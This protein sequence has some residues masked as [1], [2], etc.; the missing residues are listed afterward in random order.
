MVDLWTIERLYWQFSPP[1]RD[2]FASDPIIERLKANAAQGRVLVLAQ[3]AEGL[4]NRDPYFGTDFQGKGTGLMVHGIRSVTGYH[5]NELGRY[6]TLAQSRT[7]AGPIVLS[8]AFWRHE[9]VRYLYTNAPVAD[10]QFK[11]LLGPV[12]NSAGSTVYLYELPDGNPPAWVASAIVK[13]PDDAIA[14]AVIDPRF[15]PARFAAVSDNAPVQGSAPNAAPAPVAIA[16]RDTR[17]AADRIDVELDAPAP[18]GS[19]LV[20]SENYFPGWMA[21]IDGRDGATVRANYNLIGV[22]LVAGAR[23]IELEFD[24]DAYHTGKLVTLFALAAVLLAIVGGVLV[25]RRATRG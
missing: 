19:A 4:A 18:A 13:A 21:R 22:P 12:R 25:D 2:L 3:S 16:T 5:G 24:D 14:A 10:S 23:K 15:D 9:N 6:Q 11:Q 8:P 20:V 17:Q 1:A 7:E